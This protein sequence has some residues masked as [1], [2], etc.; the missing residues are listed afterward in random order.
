MSVPKRLYDVNMCV[1]WV[2]MKVFG[3]VMGSRGKVKWV[4]KGGK[5][6]RSS[7]D[8]ERNSGG[9]VPL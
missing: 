4:K 2:K 8:A 5:V 3:V 9:C 1:L 7:A 6:K